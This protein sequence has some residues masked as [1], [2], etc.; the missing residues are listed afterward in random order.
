MKTYNIILN[1]ANIIMGI[2]ILM[3]YGYYHADGTWHSYI[4]SFGIGWLIGVTI[5]KFFSDGGLE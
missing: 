1:I 2:M 3:L 5:S 4:I